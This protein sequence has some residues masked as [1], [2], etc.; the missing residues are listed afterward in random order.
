MVDRVETPLQQIQ[1]EADLMQSFDNENIVAFHGVFFETC[2]VCIVMDK[3]DGGDLVTGLQAHMSM[4][5][6]PDSNDIVHVAQQL[7][8]SIRYLHGRNVVHRDI[9]G[10]NYLMDRRDMTNPECHIV[11]TDFGTSTYLQPGQRLSEAVGTKLFWSP[12]FYDL[13]Y[14][15][16][17]DVW[18]LGIVMYGLITGRFPFK[19]EEAVRKKEIKVAKK[20]H[21]HCA[22]FIKSL[23]SRSES[24]RPSAIELMKHH[25]V[26][27]SANLN[28]DAT[29]DDAD[30]VGGVAGAPVNRDGADDGVR[31]RRRELFNA[32]TSE[33]V[34]TLATGRSC[35]WGWQSHELMKHHWVA[36]SA[37]LNDDATVDDAD[38]VGGVA[39]APVNRDGADDGVRERR[40]ELFKRL[41][42]RGSQNFG[43]RPVLPLGMAKSFICD[44]TEVQGASIRYEWWSGDKVAQGGFLRPVEGQRRIAG[45]EVQREA[46]RIETVKKLLEDHNI[47]TSSLKPPQSRSLDSLT[48]EVRSG[49]A[50]LMLDPTE[51]KKLVRAVDV[52]LLRIHLD[53]NSGQ[54]PRIAM[55]TSTSYT[56]GHKRTGIRLPGT[57]KEG[58]ENTRQTTLRILQQILQLGDA[59]CA[60]CNWEEI[61]RLE[62]ETE[63]YGYAGVRTVYHFEIVDCRLN[64]EALSEVARGYVSES[65]P[66]TVKDHLGTTRHF[67][68]C[69]LPDVQTPA[70]M[71]VKMHPSS[72]TS[73]L[74]RPPVGLDEE[75][76]QQ[77][78]ERLG[79]DIG[80]F[81]RNGAG[82]LRQFSSEMLRGVSALMQDADGSVKRVVD[83]VVIILVNAANGEILMEAEQ[84]LNSHQ[85][86]PLNRLPACK[87][88]PDENHFICARRLL[89]ENLMADTNQVRFDENVEF[90]EDERTSVSYPELK[91]VYRK[92]IVKAELL[93]T[94]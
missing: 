27:K 91:S 42:I 13:D 21:F 6:P 1:K 51:H 57:K 17:V 68:W 79:I 30:S 8:G 52:V 50:R 66:W 54:A 94:P 69:H 48:Q 5:G 41:D 47:D 39:G 2:F 77:Y 40:R 4:R 34:K 16:K 86:V 35:P 36:K 12:E 65:N 80:Q 75:A 92:R 43:H 23:V 37:N 15:L 49:A 19:D 83:I 74:V 85:N 44:D 9:K 33:A 78:L 73:L 46:Y 81:G 60:E 71:N 18:A 29:V 38:S 63:S 76:L 22:D 25:W 56:D 90:V 26:A 31:E 20:A 88:R 32:L 67:T 70:K 14:G 3:Y 10:D 72:T 62:E 89:V 11:L 82:S 64:L 84:L 58:H 61:D 55:E 45:A 28:D 59:S 53:S 87:C 7:G 93:R 24:S